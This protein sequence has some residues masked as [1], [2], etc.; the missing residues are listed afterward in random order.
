MND[1]PSKRQP[2]LY[3]R[4]LEQ[5]KASSIC[6]R[7]YRNQLARRVRALEII[8]AVASSGGIAGWVVF[9]DYPF[10]WSAIIAA[11]QLLDALKNVFPFTRQ[12][13]AASDL[14][15]AFELLWIDADEE[16]EN[17]YKGKLSEDEITKRRTRLRKLQLEAERKYFPEGF[18]PSEKLI[19]LATEEA[20]SYFVLTY[21]EEQSE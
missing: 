17:I 9:R 15:V 8:K 3:W 21:P 14:T 7:L 6:I 13:K 19:R 12:H 5:L 18:E 11:S 20:N 10:L 16:W 4:Q 2:S 1:T